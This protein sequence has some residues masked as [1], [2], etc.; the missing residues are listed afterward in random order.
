MNGIYDAFDERSDGYT[1]EMD[2]IL[3]DSFIRCFVSPVITGGRLLDA[4]T[5]TG[6]IAK[7]CMESGWNVTAVDI[8]EKMLKNVPEGICAQRGNIEELHFEKDSFDVTVCRQAL[9]YTDLKKALYSMA[10][11]TAKELRLGHL[12]FADVKDKV[13]WEQYFKIA[14]PYRKVMFF[15]QETVIEDILKKLEK[16]V[17]LQTQ[18]KRFTD[19]LVS[20]QRYPKREIYDKLY[21]MFKSFPKE[22]IQRN[23][24]IFT[25]N[26]EI[27]C[28]RY[29][30]FIRCIFV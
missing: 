21:E 8:N 28:D 26:G 6:I 2:W 18:E 16:N 1:A 22:F 4:G 10:A 24:I 12:Y 3:N 14:S 15:R 29:W 25:Q 17:H 23:N 20:K 9:H 5:G 27:L 11:V 19:I 7:S 30:R 13:F